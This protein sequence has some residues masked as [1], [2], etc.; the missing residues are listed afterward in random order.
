MSETTMELQTT[1]TEKRGDWSIT[2]FS[3]GFAL[4]VETEQNSRLL[5][6]IGGFVT[7][8]SSVL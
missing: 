1:V 3:F 7:Q 8:F 6:V 2:P 5:S 4:I